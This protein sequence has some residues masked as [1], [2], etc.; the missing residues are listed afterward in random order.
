M[1]TMRCGTVLKVENKHPFSDFVMFEGLQLR[2]IHSLLL[3]ILRFGSDHFWSFWI[4]QNMT[5]AWIPQL[6]AAVV[7]FCAWCSFERTAFNFPSDE[8]RDVYIGRWKYS[9]FSYGSL[10]RLKTMQDPV[11]LLYSPLL[12]HC[13]TVYWMYFLTYDI[14]MFVHLSRS[15]GSTDSLVL[16]VKLLDCL[17]FERLHKVVRLEERERGI[18]R[19]KEKDR[20]MDG[21]RAE[22][23]RETLMENDKGEGEEVTED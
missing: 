9:G 11:T 3:D 1:K 20:E 12:Q 22:K 6:P 13:N 10:Q 7:M 18:N 2:L 14:V 23:D 8:E 15:P 21:W 5:F 16:P 17:D 19:V 4:F